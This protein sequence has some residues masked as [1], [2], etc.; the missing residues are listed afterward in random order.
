MYRI[1]NLSLFIC[2]I[3]ALSTCQSGEQK[4]SYNEDIRPILNK[5]C[6]ACHGGVQQLG[7]F[8][9]LFR[10][11]ALGETDSGKKAIVPGNAKASELIKRLKHDDPELRMPLEAAPLNEEEIALISQWIDEGAY[12]EEPWAFVAPEA[13]QIPDAKSGWVT[14]NIDA[15][16]QRKLEEHG[17]S[18]N[19]QADPAIL[20]RRLSLDLI[21][22]PPKPSWVADFIAEPTDENYQ[23]PY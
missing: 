11:E 19:E 20:A 2:L 6:L 13:I 18:P 1:I 12:W 15:F 10:E 23:E 8:S 21:G 14:S 5:K 16:I 4:L 9:L 22:L 7:G 17:L 3:I